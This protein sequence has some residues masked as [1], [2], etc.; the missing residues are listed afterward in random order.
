MERSSG[1]TLVELSLTLTVAAILMTTVVPAM[2]TMVASNRMV[3]QINLFVS[4]MH[5]ARSEAIKRNRR[6]TICKGSAVTGCVTS[7]GWEQGWI[8]FVDENSNSQFDTGEELLQTAG[9]VGG[10]LTLRGN[11]WVKNYLSY[12]PSGHLRLSSGGLQMGTLIACDGRGFD[13]GRALILFHTGRLGVR[14][15]A[16][17]SATTCLTS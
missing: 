7:G 13:K 11:Q 15:T 5:M 8:S 16:A 10:T 1:F 14:E 4:S 17:S 9:P 2:Q 6:V 3:S 12:L